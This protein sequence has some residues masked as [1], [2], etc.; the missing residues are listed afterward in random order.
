MSEDIQPL[1]NIIEAAL[2]A[3]GRPMSLDELQELFGM[4][5]RPERAQ[6]REIVDA[7]R[8]DYAARGIELVEVA[9]GYRIQVRQT[10]APW[11][12]RLWEE[13]PARYSRALLETLALVAYRQPITR[14]EIEDVRGVTVSPH[15]I[16]TLQ[17][18]NWIRMVGHRDVPGHPEMF[19]TTREFLDYFGLKSLDELPSLA[20]LKDIDSLNVELDLG[21]EPAPPTL[22]AVD[23]QA[24]DPPPA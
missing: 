21:D 7:L 23:A 19:G 14:G 11:I 22:E 20:A 4:D 1:K 3:A 12:S 17:E 6:L 5:E 13:R 10:L 16:K 8:H 15:I 24:D 9:N 2:L 18:R